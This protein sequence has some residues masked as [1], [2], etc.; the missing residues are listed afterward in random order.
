MAL[1]FLKRSD[2]EGQD[3]Q[4]DFLSIE[5]QYDS[6]I[7]RTKPVVYVVRKSIEVKV[8]NV[9]S[10]EGLLTGLLTNGVNNVHGIEFRTTE[11]R[12]HR[13][14]ARAMAIRAARE[15]ADALEAELGVTRGKVYTINANDWGGYWSPS[16]G[17]WGGR[18]GGAMMQNVVQNTGGPSDSGDETLSLGQISVSASVNVSFLIE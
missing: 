18:Y 13:D 9:E 8:E 4:T 5:P 3:V 14:T 1:G 6:N 12:K 16:G 15:K 7:S 11:L 17:F 2:V 10:F